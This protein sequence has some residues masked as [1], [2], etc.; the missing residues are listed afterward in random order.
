MRIK[1]NFK[2]LITG[3]AGALVL[4]FLMA[5]CKCD[6]KQPHAADAQQKTQV[7][8]VATIAAGTLDPATGNFIYDTGEI[9]EIKLPNG[10]SL[11]EV[12]KNS[13]EARLFNFLNDSGVTVNNDDKTQGWITLD[14][15]YFDTG[16]ASLT[17]ES[18]KQIKNIAEI[19]KAFPNA[20]LKIGGYTD[21]TGSADINKTVSAERAKVVADELIK[22][23]VQEAR[24][25]SEGYGP[26]HPICE[27][28][29]TPECK[30][31]NRRV[32]VRVAQK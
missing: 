7:Q 28:N 14:R 23:G 8:E 13:T 20:V 12:G 30:A 11:V 17:A 5:S 22:L 29:D 24:V 25:S 31:Q 21:N 6:K 15:V 1:N 32:D 2:T 19:L 4:L 9:F 3:S 27:A 16:K 26:E 10:T 18:S